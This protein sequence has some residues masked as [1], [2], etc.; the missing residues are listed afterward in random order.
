MWSLNNPFF[1]SVTSFISNLVPFETSQNDRFERFKKM[2]EEVVHVIN[3]LREHEEQKNR[4]WITT[5]S[6]VQDL[7]QMVDLLI[8]EEKEFE[9]KKGEED[10][11][12]KQTKLCLDYLLKH[13]IVD[14][15]CGIAMIDE[16]VGSTELILQFLTRLFREIQFPIFSSETIHISISALVQKL[17]QIYQSNEIQS[18]LKYS[19]IEFVEVSL[20]FYFYFYRQFVKSFVRI[21]I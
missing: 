20:I 8:E 9:E 2:Y 18:S 6:V 7:N 11:M 10:E 14:T 21:V 17:I 1:T 16:P 12:N 3:D 19:I 4:D 13:Q 5:T 15:F